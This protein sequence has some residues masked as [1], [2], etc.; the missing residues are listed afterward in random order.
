MPHFQKPTKYKESWFDIFDDWDLIE[1][2]FATQYGIR[3]TQID[4]LD[5]KEFLTLLGGLMNKTPLGQMIEIRSEDDK[6]RLKTFSQEQHQIRNE[7][8]T[9]SAKKQQEYFNSLND[10]EKNIIMKNIQNIFK[11]AF[12]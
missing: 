11:N 1:A 5:F 12:A 6:D 4:D 3:L 7:W 10:E 9:K 8:R 2:S